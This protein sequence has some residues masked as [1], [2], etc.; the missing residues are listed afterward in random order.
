M[1]FFWVFHHGR[2]YNSVMATGKPFD[3]FAR[4]PLRIQRD[5]LRE[6]EVLL[7][8]QL[9]VANA[10]DQRALTWGGFLI[11]AATAALGG[12]IALLI[13]SPPDLSL[14]V[15]ALGFAL[16]ILKAAWDAIRT[17]APALWDFPGIRPG[18]WLP[19]GDWPP[20]D[21]PEACQQA[22][23]DRARQIDRAIGDNIESAR[24]RAQRMNSS[25]RLALSTVGV[26]GVLLVLVLIFRCYTIRE[27]TSEIY[28]TPACACA[29]A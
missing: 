15:L 24:R 19:D 14:S 27:P 6:G 29:R 20:P 17:V 4:L 18:N 11:A 21:E 23:N 7:Q 5:A 3:N 28:R 22:R 13:K 8:A 9:T 1:L 25:F 16:C 26:A 2:D 12:G 10:A